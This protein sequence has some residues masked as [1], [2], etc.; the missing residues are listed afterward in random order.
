M[1][2]LISVSAQRTLR[3]IP[4]SL[5]P[6]NFI[7]ARYFSVSSLVQ[8]Q[9]PTTLARLSQVLIP[10]L[11]PAADDLLTRYG[12]VRQVA[13]G[14]Y[15]LLP[16]GHL[17]QANVERVL[18]KHMVSIGGCEVS[19][20][21]MSLPALWEQTG[22]AGNK[23]ILRLKDAR[24]SEY[25][26]C[27]THEEEITNIVA[28]EVASYR[29]LPLKLYQ[30][31]RKYRDE[32]RPRGGLLRGR[33]FTMKDMYTF[34]VTAE[35][36]HHSYDQVQTAY[37]AFFTDL[38]VPFV[39]AEADSG[40]IGGSL[41][42]EYHYLNPTGEDTVVTCTDCKYT[43]NEE[44]AVSMPSE[45]Q[46]LA[47]EARVEY[48]VSADSLTL[49]AC[50]FPKD[51]EFNA[52]LI[53]A[54]LPT[55][56]ID[57]SIS[58]NESSASA[59]AAFMATVESDTDMYNKRL[60]RLMDPRVD[61]NTDLPDLPFQ[62]SRST[63]T[64]L[65]DVPLV[66]PIS[67]ECCPSCDNPSLTTERAIEVGHTF[68]LGTKY[69]EP[70]SATVSTKESSAA[71]V[72]MGCY[73]IGVSRLLAAV[74]LA[75]HDADGLAWPAS[76]APYTAVVVAQNLDVGLEITNALREAGVN[77]VL[78]DR[79]DLQFGQKLRDAR[80]LGFPYTV[81]AGKQYAQIGKLEVQ[82]RSRTLTEL[83]ADPVLATLADLPSIL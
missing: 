47:K 9:Q 55:D 31:T 12:Y 75:T 73:G 22:R 80:Q 15:H 42:H 45:D 46:P 34:D 68:Y 60:I 58:A 1:L 28:K 24:G 57:P 40:A 29:K 16:L 59:L 20:A 10:K 27:P 65:I 8:H 35:E 49:V 18:R 50:Y 71:I 81:V 78:D 61:R 26:L 53:D 19:L 36:A 83:K 23:E 13:A 25:L 3:C 77:A 6:T 67:G 56:T 69:T 52:L 5:Q 79:S 82:A 64:T 14:T 43:A 62:P 72:E 39:I 33:E 51:R 2:R 11:Q 41:S 30:I 48:R 66:T 74:A 4:H 63:T 32:K 38:E 7:S 17:V 44:K 76:I 70:L 21:S 54:E 37:N